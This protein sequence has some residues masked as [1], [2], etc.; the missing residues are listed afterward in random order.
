MMWRH[1]TVRADST[2]VEQACRSKQGDEVS[3]AA[4]IKREREA[5]LSA[6][7]LY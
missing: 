7:C 5:S 2:E 4:E 3:A 6:L 1:M